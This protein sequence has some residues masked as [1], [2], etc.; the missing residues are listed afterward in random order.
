ME[1]GSTRLSAKTMLSAQ[2]A[3]LVVAQPL[4]AARRAPR[5]SPVAC[6]AAQ[7]Q[8]EQVCR[9]GSPLR[10]PA[11]HV[12]CRGARRVGF[13]DAGPLRQWAVC[14]SARLQPGACLYSPRRSLSQAL[15]RRALALAGAAVLLSVAAPA[16]Q[17]R[18][19]FA[20]RREAAPLCVAAA[21]KCFI[22]GP[23][24]R[25]FLGFG[26]KS[27]EETYTEETRA[28]VAQMRVRG[29]GPSG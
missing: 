29:P 26:E 6:S 20:Q 27:Q 15:S 13:F 17:V 19:P 23:Q 28:V 22:P 11:A 1:C 8:P 25:A 12:S 2:V 3:S 21:L 9:P 7:Q 5:R 18:M 16:Q 24:A 10:G 14:A 4:A